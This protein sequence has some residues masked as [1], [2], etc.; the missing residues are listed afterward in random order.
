MRSEDLRRREAPG[1]RPRLRAVLFSPPA[2]T[3]DEVQE[4]LRRTAERLR[5][6][7]RKLAAIEA[8]DGVDKHRIRAAIAHVQMYSCP[9][10]YVVADADEPPPAQGEIVEIEHEAFVVAR[11]A[12]SP[13]PADPR[14]CAI[15]LRAS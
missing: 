6:A 12:P 8:L 2:S 3:V 14:R 15:L 13:F 1:C 4:E 5:R 10:G 9:S 11:L 7:E